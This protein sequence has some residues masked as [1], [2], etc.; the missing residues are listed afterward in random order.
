M[1]N[2]L[3]KSTPTWLFVLPTDFLN[4][5]EQI[6][7][8]YVY[9]LNEKGIHCQIII[10]SR[11]KGMSWDD[12]QD[13]N[14][15]HYFPFKT[16]TL[17]LF[18]LPIFLLRRLD[19]GIHATFS[20]QSLINGMLGA[21]KR[22]GILHRRCQVI[23]RESNSIFLLVSG[24]KKLLYISFYKLG[25]T[26]VDLMIVQTETMKN[27]LEKAIPG[28]TKMINTQVIENPI[29]IRTL[30]E[31]VQE[32]LNDLP[33][34]FIVAAGRL[35]KVKGFDLLI[36][37]F[38]KIQKLYPKLTL[39]ILGSGREDKNLKEL[40]RKLGLE[41]NVIFKGHVNN[42]MPFFA[43]ASACVISSRLEGFPNVLLQ[44]MFANSR[45][46]S[47]LSAGGIDEIEGLYVC[48]PDDLNG[49]TEAILNCLSSEKN[50]RN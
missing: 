32:K 7:R 21:C 9:F 3:K 24:V 49:L 25:Y 50:N 5:A 16:Y 27:N 20:S 19:P 1:P 13:I 18:F 31:Q 39:V 4:G 42:V 28:L 36:K 37:A 38:E 43:E 47:T 11:R 30:E 14:S 41:N 29:S 40:S 6:L 12:L 46:V 8:N 33:D 44:M 23:I 15:V 45:I 2:H 34:T 17:G 10:L 48:N 26:S 22:I 35:E